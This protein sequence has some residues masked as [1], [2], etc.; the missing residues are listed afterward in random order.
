MT[1][2]VSYAGNTDF[3][4]STSA[5][6]TLT[7][8]PQ[9]FTITLASPT[10]TIQTQHHLTTTLTLTSLNGFADSLALTC[11]NLPTYVT[12]RPTPNP[13]PLTA[14]GSTIVSLYLDTDSVLGYARNHLTP[15]PGNSPTA[16]I[17]LGLLLVPIGLFAGV[18]T[19]SRR[20]TRLRLL[21]LLFALIPASLAIAGC[22]EIIY[23]YDVPPSAAAGTYTI[24]ITAAGA[25]TGIAHTANLTLT[26]TP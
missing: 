4:A 22:G 5:P 25:T 15:L 9:D 14:N 12:C 3:L 16:P 13:A 1:I 11:A 19:F 26:V 20:T 8:V 18:A 24:P 2:T 6:I 7:I 21:L 23:P 10:V 17:N